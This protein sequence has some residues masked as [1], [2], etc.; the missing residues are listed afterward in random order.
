V[1]GIGEEFEQSYTEDVALPLTMEEFF[2][3][4]TGHGRTLQETHEFMQQYYSELI[5]KRAALTDDVSKKHQ[6]N[7][8]KKQQ[9][10]DM[11]EKALNTIEKLESEIGRLQRKWQSSNLP[12][13][14]RRFKQH[15]ELMFS[16]PLGQKTEE[17]KCSFLLLWIGDK[18][19]DISNTW[20]L[21]EDEAKLLKTYYDGFT[22]YTKPKAN[23]IFARYKFHEEM[24][25]SEAGVSKHITSNPTLSS[26]QRFVE[27]KR[28]FC[29]G[30]AKRIL[31]K[32]KEDGKDPYLA[33]LEYRNTPVDGLKSPAQILMSRRLRSIL[34]TTAKQLQPQT[35]PP[36]TVQARREECQRR[37]RQHYNKAARPLPTLSP[38]AP[39]R[40]QQDDGHWQP[41]TVIQ[42]AE[43]PR[44]YHIKTSDGQIF[45]Q[46]RRHLLAQDSSPT[47]TMQQQE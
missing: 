1:F 5:T 15:T 10:Q 31:T 32:A 18:G 13:A 46:N 3:R 20:A 16:G 45:R 43:T 42:P 12:D 14:L 17:Q 38:R 8:Q 11:T 21:T 6:K 24:Q 40:F 37:Q 47:A 19:R 30:T 23:P 27:K 33:L 4:A 41:A 29:P 28:L 36:N 25:D 44:S 2:M 35:T 34:P 39:I 7:M 9:L 22:A 26:E